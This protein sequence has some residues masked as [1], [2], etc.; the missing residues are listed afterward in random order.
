MGSS[1]SSQSF[2][3]SS[4]RSLRSSQS[5]FASSVLS[6]EPHQRTSCASSL[7]QEL[8][9]EDIEEGGFPSSPA[10][11]QRLLQG[12]MTD[13][14]SPTK[15]NPSLGLFPIK[16]N[17]TYPWF[18][19]SGDCRSTRGEKGGRNFKRHQD[20]HEQRFYCELCVGSPSNIKYGFKCTCQ[21]VTSN[22]SH[23][24]I[25]RLSQKQN[26]IP[27]YARSESLIRHLEKEH[28]L[29]SV[30]ASLCSSQWHH[31][32][33][34]KA[35]ACGICEDNFLFDNAKEFNEHVN[36]V[37]WSQG[38]TWE[39][40]WSQDRVIGKLISGQPRMLY[41][42]QALMASSVVQKQNLT[43]VDVDT[44]RL[45]F[46][47]EMAHLEP[48]VLAQMA[49]STARDRDDHQSPSNHIMTPSDVLRLSDKRGD[50]CLVA[51]LA[52][53]RNNLLKSSFRYDQLHN[54][55]SLHPPRSSSNVP[56]AASTAETYNS[57]RYCSPSHRSYCSLTLK[58]SSTTQPPMGPDTFVHPGG[59]PSNAPPSPDYEAMIST[60]D[61]TFL[62]MPDKP[63]TDGYN[64]A[65]G[66][67]SMDWTQTAQATNH[68]TSVNGYGPST[69]P[70]R[71]VAS[72]P[73][74]QGKMTLH[75][76][77]APVYQPQNQDEGSSARA[78]NHATGLRR[79][80]KMKS[81]PNLRS[82]H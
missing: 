76:P 3:P 22:M 30:E 1:H 67:N 9:P 54:Q 21:H 65:F 24:E 68:A 36:R 81:F 25:H 8:R 48:T 44:R 49:Y 51:S 34:R 4:W 2:E 52:A 73:H 77:K 61:P 40:R 37:H 42:W 41:A 63:S 60:I 35:L 47:L 64:A 80:S 66:Q 79:P 10:S 17:D 82:K 75:I 13:Q 71:T 39:G 50:G 19:T 55:H 6:Q 53:Q 18:C 7:R 38:Q 27:L 59:I 58:C 14:E 43:W 69:Y 32:F 70:K 62:Q 20:T 26:S 5:S 72:A 15:A 16:N 45:R 12:L 57:F 74:A 46:E 29:P 78:S 33:E 31:R 11:Q 23:L 56:Q 28:D